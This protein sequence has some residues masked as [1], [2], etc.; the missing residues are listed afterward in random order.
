[1][2]YFLRESRTRTHTTVHHQDTHHPA[3]PLPRVP[4][5]PAC[6]YLAHCSSRSQWSHRPDTVHQASF[7]YSGL[8]KI[9]TWSKP[10]LLCGQNGPV[11]N[12]HFREKTLL[13][14]RTFYENAIFDVFGRKVSKLDISETPLVYHWFYCS[15]SLRFPLG[16]W[17]IRKFNNK[18]HENHRFWPFS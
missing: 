4:P 5:H 14:V 8:V 1:M 17:Q 15:A 6:R 9:P 16:F 2:P 13:S 3:H 10:P 18:K 11:Q 12:C 7:G